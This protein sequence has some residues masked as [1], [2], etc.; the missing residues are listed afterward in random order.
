MSVQKLLLFVGGWIPNEADLQG[1]AWNVS[2]TLL[3]NGYKIDIPVLLLWRMPLILSGD[4]LIMRGV[5]E[6]NISLKK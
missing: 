3:T 4:P 6:R 2:P 1:K 5:L